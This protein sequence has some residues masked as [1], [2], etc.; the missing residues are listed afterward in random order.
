MRSWRSSSAPTPEPPCRP[1]ESRN[2][3]PHWRPSARRTPWVTWCGFPGLEKRGRPVAVLREVQT[4]MASS[5]TDYGPSAMSS[6]SSARVSVMS[7]WNVS[8]VKST[9][10]TVMSAIAAM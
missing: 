2:C 6:R 3:V 9:E 8:V 7:P 1:S 5:M 10:T 4:S